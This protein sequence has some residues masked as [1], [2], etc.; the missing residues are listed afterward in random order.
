MK[1]AAPSGWKHAPGM[2]AV[3]VLAISYAGVCVAL[4]T[5]GIFAAAGSGAVFAGPPRPTGAG[6]VKEGS[7]T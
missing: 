1:R 3:Q 6:N 2:R 5:F 7:E 4:V